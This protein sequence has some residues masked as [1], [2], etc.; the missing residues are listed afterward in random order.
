MDEQTYK[1]INPDTWKRKDLFEFFK[2]FDDPF[3]NITA[4]LDVTALY[5]FCKQNQLS[6]FLST[7]HCALET[8]NEIPEFRLRLLDGKPVEFETVHIGSTVLHDD[9]TFSF[10]Y[11][12][13]AA[14]IFEF[15]RKGKASLDKQLQSKQLDPRLDELNAVHCSVIPWIAFTAFKHARQFGR[16]DSIPKIV[17]GKVFEENGHRKMPHSVEVNHALVD[18]FHVGNYFKKLQEQLDGFSGLV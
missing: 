14:D 2:D 12:E 11:F 13:R 10:C 15:N 1:V 6:F 8:V 9:D 3:F 18:G 17:F 5:R 16:K 7:L 4:N